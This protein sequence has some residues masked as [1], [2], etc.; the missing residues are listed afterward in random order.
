MDWK[1]FRPIAKEF[2]RAGIGAYD[3]VSR[4]ALGLLEEM[5]RLVAEAR[6]EMEAE[7]PASSP[8]AKQSNQVDAETIKASLSKGLQQELG[9]HPEVFRALVQWLRQED[10]G[11]PW[12]LERLK[13]R[14]FTEH[15]KSWISNGPNQPWSAADVEHMLDEAY[16]THLT[17][18]THWPGA[19]VSNALAKLIP[20]L[21]DRLTP[22]GELVSED[23]FSDGL[24]FLAEAL[25]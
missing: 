10:K 25:L 18:Q 24:T 1:V 11:I 7:A 17:Q 16:V 23:L 21:I 4:M 6:A 20:V 22:L 15:L 3:N 19:Q 5:N 13:E 8:A 12:L 2:V 9:S 14:G